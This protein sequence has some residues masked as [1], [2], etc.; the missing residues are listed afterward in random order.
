[1]RAKSELSQ[2]QQRLKRVQRLYDYKPSFGKEECPVCKGRGYLT[3]GDH[4]C[5]KCNGTGVIYK[6]KG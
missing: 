5:W 3:T 2:S 1:M 6:D 4:H